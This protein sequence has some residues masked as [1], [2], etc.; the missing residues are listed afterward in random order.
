[1]TKELINLGQMKPAVSKLRAVGGFMAGQSAVEMALLVP[2][3]LLL[4]T[5]ISDFARVY[6]LSVAVNNAARAGT[7]YGGQNQTNSVDLAGMQ[8]A[9]LADATNIPGITATASTFCECPGTT[10][11]FIC[12]QNPQCK[13]QHTYVEVKTSATFKTTL[14]YPGIP[15]TVAVNGDSVMLAAVS[16]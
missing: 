9:A 4:L 1:M 16:P 3:L 10:S 12:P 6:Y 14:H 11:H 2:V 8:N 15:N 7:G 5:G 13:D